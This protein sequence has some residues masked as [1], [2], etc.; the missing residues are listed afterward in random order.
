MKFT[1]KSDEQIAKEESARMLWDKGVYSYEILE[2]VTFG[3]KTIKTSD[4]KSG[5]GNDM[6]QLVVKLFNDDGRE[7]VVIDYITESLAFKLKHLA[8]SHGMGAQYDAGELHAIDFIGKCGKAKV[9]VS[10]GKLKDD[11]SGDKYPDKNSIVDY[12]VEQA[13]GEG[14]FG[15]PPPGHPA[16]TPIHDDTIPF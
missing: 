10:K 13:T 3:T 12:V 2:H 4:T 6:I 1:P 15:L 9:G 5:K 8:Y 11:G 16:S 7:S 14:D